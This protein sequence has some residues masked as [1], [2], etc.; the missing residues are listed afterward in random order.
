MWLLV[1]CT[2]IVLPLYVHSVCLHVYLFVKCAEGHPFLGY[3]NTFVFTN[4]TTF[5]QLLLFYCFIV[6]LLLF[7]FSLQ[8]CEKHICKLFVWWSLFS[9]VDMLSVHVRVMCMR[10]SISFV[11]DIPSANY[12]RVLLYWICIAR[13]NGLCVRK[14]EADDQEILFPILDKLPKLYS[15]AT[16]RRDRWNYLNA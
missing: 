13:L 14:S 9:L 15:Y 7:F 2:T 8:L 4:I 5:L 6:L 10:V 12:F 1:V 3:V 16:L 11:H